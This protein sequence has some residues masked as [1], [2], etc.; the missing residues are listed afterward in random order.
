MLTKLLMGFCIMIRRSVLDEVGL[1]DE[2]LVLGSDDLE[3]CWR[4]ST[5]EFRLAIARDVYVEHR[6]GTSFE[7]LPKRQISA[8]LKQSTKALKSKLEAYYGENRVPTSTEL[9]GID[10]FPG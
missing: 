2:N 5:H 6:A 9:W 10:I 1:L 4:L 3:L 8:K 7:S